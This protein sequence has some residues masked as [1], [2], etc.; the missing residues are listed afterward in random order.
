VLVEFEDAVV[1]TQIE[2]VGG[3]HALPSVGR[4]GGCGDSAG[5]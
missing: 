3:L 5:G 1:R 2:P 4:Y